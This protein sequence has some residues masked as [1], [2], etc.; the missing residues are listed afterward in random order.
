VS[1]LLFGEI[2]SREESH[3]KDGL[4]KTVQR[5]LRCHG[6]CIRIHRDN[7]WVLAFRTENYIFMFREENIMV[8]TFYTFYKECDTS[9]KGIFFIHK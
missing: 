6:P 4:S 9:I 5:A 7:I 1:A 3:S 8:I 2:F